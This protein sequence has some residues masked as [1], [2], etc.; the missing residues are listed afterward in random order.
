MKK[1]LLL[2]FTLTFL[3]VQVIQA[4]NYVDKWHNDENGLPQNTVKDIAKDERGFIW[5]A[6]ENGLVRYNGK[7]FNT[8]NDIPGIRSQRMSFFYKEDQQL[9][10]VTISQEELKISQ[11]KPISEGKFHPRP[12]LLFEEISSRNIPRNIFLDNPY[13][14]DFYLNSTSYYLVGD[15]EFIHIYEKENREKSV[16]KIALD[17]LNEPTAFYEKNGEAYLFTKNNLLKFNDSKLAFE[18]LKTPFNEDS[19]FDAVLYNNFSDQL[20]LNTNRE[21]HLLNFSDETISTQIIH[22]N[23]CIKDEYIRTFY[24]D[25]DLEITFF[26]SWSNGLKISKKNRF[27]VI[28]NPKNKSQN[29][30]YAF[31][32]NKDGEIH[33]AT[34]LSIKD[35]KIIANS[36]FDEDL[37]IT[38]HYLSPTGNS[39]YFSYRNPYL[40]AVTINDNNQFQTEKL[41]DIK[42]DFSSVYANSDSLVYFTTK[43]HR[44]VKDNVFARYTT[45]TKKL[46]TIA[47]IP[48]EVI[49]MQPKKSNSEELWLATD[50]GLYSHNQITNEI[51]TIK[52][53]KNLNIRSINEEKNGIWIGT[54]NEGFYYLDKTN[55]L[56]TKFPLDHNQY[57]KTTHHILEDDFGFMWIST[58]KGLFR[59]KKQNLIDYVH[60]REDNILYQYFNTS[61]GLKTNEFNGRCFPCAKKLANGELVFPSMDGL[62]FFQPEDFLSIKNPAK[63]YL[64]QLILDGKTLSLQD[65]IALPRDFERLEVQFDGPIFYQDQRLNYQFQISDRL[66]ESSKIKE[67]KFVFTQLPPGKHQ[68]FINYPTGKS[69]STEK[70]NLA[71][72]VPLMFYE[73]NWF[74]I[75]SVFVLIILVGGI[76]FLQVKRHQKQKI[77]LEK[78]INEN[79]SQLRSTINSLKSSRDTLENQ[80]QSLKKIV[81][82]ISHDIKSPLQYLAYGID[83][84]NS[85]LKEVKISKDA[86]E[87]LEAIASS[88]EKLQEFTE[89]ILTY[90]K[91]VLNN[92]VTQ[93][94]T[95]NIYEILQSKVDLFEQMSKNK[96]IEVTVKAPKDLEFKVNKNLISVIIHNI[97]DNA[98]KN[99]LNGRIEISAKTVANQLL[100]KI[101]DTGSGMNS[102]TLE[103]YREIFSKESNHTSVSGSGLGLYIVSESARLMNAKIDIESIKNQGTTFMMKLS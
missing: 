74:K 60:S 22:D 10:A 33:T 43:D 9:K 21:I 6:T 99:T 38:P 83:F 69:R 62:V 45:Q 102:D 25:E 20:I 57:L 50:M 32:Q 89:N 64:D 12:G 2:L 31:H 90:S 103:R 54:Y 87:N 30:L 3:G 13:E 39:H 37:I 35:K 76:I 44:R 46:D 80:I 53:T 23:T 93:K 73:K 85:E 42:S 48:Y 28:T 59:V 36:T 34:G 66:S 8:F 95:H 78:I 1:H 27:N 88:V 68:L 24:Y 67:G 98:I 97:L 11:G 52:S 14:R 101:S 70:I 63:I 91:A 92:E 4:Q 79:T 29:I 18:A 61:D 96:R 56:L 55:H 7:D 81:A 17:D 58:N 100:I 51:E 94:S 71:F 40:V 82:S 15:S 86:E 49:F 84:L 72:D 75:L 19:N 65:E 47:E 5:L 77:Q 26:G 41:L 16:K